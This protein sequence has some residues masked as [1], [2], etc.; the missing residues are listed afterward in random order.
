MASTRHKNVTV[1]STQTVELGEAVPG[2]VS[3]WAIQY[4]G[5]GSDNWTMSINSRSVGDGDLTPTAKSFYDL[6]AG[7][8]TT[9]QPASATATTGHVVVDSSGQ[10]VEIAVTVTAGGPKISAVAI[11]G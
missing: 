10:H 7:A 5:T 4:E 11:E 9:T 1:T 8:A 3:R 2:R 6:V